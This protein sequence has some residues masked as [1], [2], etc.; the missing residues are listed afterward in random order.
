MDNFFD[1]LKARAPEAEARFAKATEALKQGTVEYQ[2]ATQNFQRLQVEHQAANSELNSLKILINVETQK[3]AAQQAS[4]LASAGMIP[5]TSPVIPVAPL[6]GPK[7]PTPTPATTTES[8][9]NK[10]EIIRDL[11]RQHA[12]GMTPGDVWRA[13]KSQI[14]RRNYVY[15]VLGRL[16]DRDQVMVRRGKYYFKILAK[17]EDAKG[18]G[19]SVQ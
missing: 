8:D 11:L 6:V 1:L 3:R 13:V 4:E 12:N 15:A 2:A 5:G 19:L 7:E 17:P 10:T 16:K 9:V 14:P 18:E